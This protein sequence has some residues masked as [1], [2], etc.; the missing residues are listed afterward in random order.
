ML[1][2]VETDA[3]TPADIRQAIEKANTDTDALIDALVDQQAPDGLT[4][5]A[6]KLSDRE[7]VGWFIDLE[8]VPYE[9]PFS[10]MD[11]LPTIAP[12]LYESLRRRFERVVAKQGA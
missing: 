1:C 3:V 5:D 6:S 11:F 4:Y 2:S 9:R 7:F 12:P 10:V 8:H